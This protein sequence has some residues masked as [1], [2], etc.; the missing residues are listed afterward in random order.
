MKSKTMTLTAT[1]LA[2]CAGFALGFLYQARELA[3]KDLFVANTVGN[4]LS[5]MNRLYSLLSGQARNHQDDQ[6]KFNLEMLTIIDCG[7]FIKSVK[8]A[9]AGNEAQYLVKGLRDALRAL[10]A[11]GVDRKGLV[12]CDARVLELAKN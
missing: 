4:N 12:L 8:P 6:N 11:N 1:V 7:V 3:R 10:D 5:Q 2:L 9:A